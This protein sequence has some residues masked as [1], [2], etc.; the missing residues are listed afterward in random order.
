M[1]ITIILGG[2]V[3]IAGQGLPPALARLILPGVKDKNIHTGFSGVVAHGADAAKGIGH[4]LGM[5]AKLAR[6]GWHLEVAGLDGLRADRQGAVEVKVTGAG[7]QG[8]E[9][10]LIKLMLSRPGQ[11]SGRE[12][13]LTGA[14]GGRYRVSTELPA[15]GAWLATLRLESGRES[16]VLERRLGGE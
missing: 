5:E 15:A 11:A 4:H 14:G 7:G 9:N 13:V 2:L 12:L 10:V 1:V 6:L 8:V 16:I 3:Y